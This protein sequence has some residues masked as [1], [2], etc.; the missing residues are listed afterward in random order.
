M[1][2]NIL[3]L[4]RQLK[5]PVDLNFSYN[6]LSLHYEYCAIYLVLVIYTNCRTLKNI[7]TML[8]YRKVIDL[9]KDEVVK[10]WIF[11]MKNL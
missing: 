4:E 10:G 1:H 6:C 5:S 8:Q 11:S 2:Y 3:S 7:E 9:A